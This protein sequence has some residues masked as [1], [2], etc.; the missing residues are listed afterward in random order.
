MAKAVKHQ[1]K[2]LVLMQEEY[3]DD[4][5]RKAKLFQS[6]QLKKTLLLDKLRSKIESEPSLSPQQRSALLGKITAEFLEAKQ[7]APEITGSTG[8]VQILK[9]ADAPIIHAPIIPPPP[10]PAAAAAPAPAESEVQLLDAEEEPGGD[11]DESYET[12]AGEPRNLS[13]LEETTAAR[14]PKSKKKKEDFLAPTKFVPRKLYSNENL[15]QVF[16][17]SHMF[18]HPGSKTFTKHMLDI[19]SRKDSPLTINRDSGVLFKHVPGEEPEEIKGS[20]INTLIDKIITSAPSRDVADVPGAEELASALA[21]D[22]DTY[23]A[24]IRNTSFLQMVRSK[25]GPNEKRL[26]TRREVAKDEAAAKDAQ[27]KGQPTKRRKRQVVWHLDNV[28][29]WHHWH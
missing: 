8:G 2:R 27:G 13:D 29:N 18:K 14:E 22:P 19:L 9:G 15:M 1:N 6:P 4:M 20:H 10:P 5:L 16:E 21:S 7:S 26:R 28:P 3:Y 17:K 25:Q 11:L 24:E 23:L 12:A